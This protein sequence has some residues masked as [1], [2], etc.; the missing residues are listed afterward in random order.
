MTTHVLQLKNMEER[1]HQWC[2]LD[3]TERR[4]RKN[5][6]LKTYFTATRSSLAVKPLLI[7]RKCCLLII[8][9]R[10]LSKIGDLNFCFSVSIVESLYW[11]LE[12]GEGMNS[13][14][15]E[16]IHCLPHLLFWRKKSCLSVYLS[17]CAGIRSKFSLSSEV[18]SLLIFC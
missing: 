17:A 11:D 7:F 18:I 6:E 15:G 1:G 12:V 3:Y 9:E 8:S 4:W 13:L 10:A 16:S 5:K 2:A 14:L